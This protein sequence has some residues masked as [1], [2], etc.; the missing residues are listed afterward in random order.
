MAHSS[1]RQDQRKPDVVMLCDDVKDVLVD[2]RVS[3]GNVSLSMEFQK[4]EKAALSAAEV[5]QYLEGI[6]SRIDGTTSRD[7]GGKRTHESQ[8]IVA[9]K[10]AKE[11]HTGAAAN[12]QE[13]KAS[14]RSETDDMSRGSSSRT[15]PLSLW[16]FDRIGV[17]KSE[18]L[19]FFED[20]ELF[21]L[22]SVALFCCDPYR[23]GYEPLIRP[24]I[25]DSTL[26]SSVEGSI[27][28][29]P[30]R[31]IHPGLMVYDPA[32]FS[33]TGSALH[34][35]YGIVGRGTVVLPIRT[36]RQSEPYDIEVDD[37][38]VAKFSW[39][40]A[41]RPREDVLI[42]KIRAAISLR[43]QRHLPD[44]KLSLAIEKTTAHMAFL[45]RTYLEGLHGRV[46]TEPRVL[47]ILVLPHY[48]RLRDAR[49]LHE[50]KSVFLDIVRVHRVIY[51]K[52]RILHRDLSPGNFMINRD[53][54]GH[55]CGILNDW[56]L[57]EDMTS[58][59]IADSS[60]LRTGTLPFMAVELLAEHQPPHR[61][62]H[63]LE[64]FLYVLVWVAIHYE[65][66]GKERP[67]NS[68]IAK[69]WTEGGWSE[70]RSLKMSFLTD[71]VYYTPIMDAVTPA[72]VPLRDAWI[73][74]L[75]KLF[76]RYR[77]SAITK[78][79]AED[80]RPVLEDWDA[81]TAGETEMYEQF[82]EVLYS[83]NRR[84]CNVDVYAYFVFPMLP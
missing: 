12:V 21:V 39:P 80:P 47:Q 2:G 36:L 43:W 40:V 46:Q 25:V 58:K 67:F 83:V 71:A 7:A 50:F 52:A 14:P 56:D 68:I 1:E 35:E 8:S 9:R 31:S 69:D 51:T 76:C 5:E 4:K 18:D 55:A 53:C 15:R 81:E 48:Q 23:L 16:Y 59:E 65:L 61:Y 49:T 32:K 29:L 77:L 72:F 13:A 73:V 11:A 26:L 63:D 75:R 60:R 62:R 33:I 17:V 74:P 24:S 41:M 70:V 28:D 22:I 19:Y 20:P 64:S 84:T 30:Y 10:R 3:F 38:L 66:Q 57:G 78:Q 6:H 37:D 42:Q 34:V 44:L 54:N 45:P 82:M 79:E 27:L